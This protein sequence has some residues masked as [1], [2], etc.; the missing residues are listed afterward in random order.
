M[1]TSSRHNYF[2]FI[3]FMLMAS[4]YLPLVFNNLPPYIRSH[5]LWTII[6]C[7]S[8]LLFNNEI[9]LKKSIVYLLGYGLFL[10]LATST[11][12]NQIDK[13]NYRR[14]FFDFYEISIGI[15]VITYFH[16]SKDYIG[17]AKITKWAIIFLFITAIMTIVS[18]AIDPLYARALTGIGELS[19]ETEI[20][21]VLNFRRFGGGNY[22]TAAA[23]MSL[24]PIMI[25]YYKNIKISLFSKKQILIFLAVTFFALLGM[26]IFGNILVAIIFSVFAIM[27]MK[28]IRQTFLSLSLLVL[29][30][31]IIPKEAYVNSLL[32][33][34]N[35]FE[36]G[37]VINYK[38]RD[39][40]TFIETGADVNDNTTDAGLR[41]G[42]YPMLINAFVKSPF[43]GYYYLS[44]GNDN[45]YDIN[46]G[47][48]YWMNKITV[49]G[50][51]GLLLFG[52]IFYIFLKTNLKY[53]NQTYKFFYILASFSILSYGL[54]KNIA[55]RETW[56]A[57]FIIIPGLYYLPLLKK[58]KNKD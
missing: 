21:A 25:F 47:H 58:S 46:G 3:V 15:S 45:D 5:H 16:L 55:G 51:I 34:G 57:F 52:I 48:L 31:L 36:E 30:L 27:G 14:L 8:L 4:T 32:S 50:L 54:I 1:G 22:S 24:F 33:I 49:T 28:K 35:N 29:I 12:W 42:R 41:A 17:L 40:A 26:Q 39:L 53:F 13:W 2:S 56:Y 43:L 11:I 38:C 9:F 20:E 19:D 18:S 44:E 23:F 7:I 6:W 37:S 10:L